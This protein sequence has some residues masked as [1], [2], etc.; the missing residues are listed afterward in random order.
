MIR[1]ELVANF[2]NNRVV[3]WLGAGTSI[4]AGLPN[5]EGLIN[6]LVEHFR[7]NDLLSD[8][9]N[10]KILTLNANKSC[11]PDIAE[12]CKKAS[13]NDYYS[14]ILDTFSPFPAKEDFKPPSYYYWF[15]QIGVR[16][17][18][19]TNFDKLAEDALKWDSF[20][21]MDTDDF[22]NYHKN[23][24]P[25]IFHIHGIYNK[26][27]T[28]IHTRSEMERLSGKDGSLARNTLKNLFV[29]NTVLF[30][31]YS[32]SDP[33][34][35]WIKQ[36]ILEEYNLDPDMYI[37][38]QNTRKKNKL[39]STNINKFKFQYYTLEKDAPDPHMAGI[40]TWFN[41]LGKELGIYNNSS[42][43]K[44]I[45]KDFISYLSKPSIENRRRFYRGGACSW[46][47]IK[48]GFT[49][50]RELCDKVLDRIN[51]P[52]SAIIA[53]SEAAGEG[54]STVLK[55]IGYAAYQL[56][57]DVYEVIDYD[58]YL[59]EKLKH[60]KNKSVILLDNA[61]YYGNFA[62]E[63]SVIRESNIPIFLILAT[64]TIEWKAKLR[65]RG[66]EMNKLNC[67][68]E[69]ESLDLSKLLISNKIVKNMNYED[70]SKKLLDETNHFL[71]A[72]MW[73]VTHGKPLEN[74]LLH[75]VNSIAEMSNGETML[76]ALAY[77]STIESQINRGR[78]PLK[79]TQIFFSK[80]LSMNEY[81]A[82]RLIDD[83]ADEIRPSFQNNTVS[84]RHPLI[85]KLLCH[86]MMD[87]AVPLV[88][89]KLVLQKIII[90]A[91]E[92]GR[93]GYKYES[94][95]LWQIPRSYG[96]DSNAMQ[97]IDYYNMIT[98]LFELSS[99]QNPYLSNIWDEWANIEWK[100]MGNS[101]NARKIL[102]EG[103]KFNNNDSLL[104]YQLDNLIN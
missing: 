75:A 62:N 100:V 60:L 16:W 49:V 45:N 22:P 58:E 66:I 27:N 71:L 52:Q 37:L 13:A 59:F 36:N 10:K 70:L 11:Y 29:N 5:W 19:T 40:Q 31:G 1:K 30:I 9:E 15:S 12:I 74:I 41:K 3:I 24:R 2:K 61:Q 93:E 43:W 83:L 94:D 14:V 87:G 90:T 104:K 95:L 76:H 25:I 99:K 17:I 42:P 46:S 57:Y 18:I 44:E 8:Y 65:D 67:L 102:Q 26:K 47:L 73:V 101:D 64:R 91:G 84:T 69:N 92:M 56:G 32:F 39:L 4:S 6:R 96:S 54:K 80:L 97:D 34:L 88:S 85:A 82:R 89:K 23:L 48:Y 20:T 72:A 68:T 50:R 79:C 33:V 38:Q 77:I 53:I 28:L 7:N 78:S 35:I 21:W 63:M 81:T 103:L 86:V 51:N 98:S 55:Q